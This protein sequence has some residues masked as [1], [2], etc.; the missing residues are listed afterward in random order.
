MGRAPILAWLLLCFILGGMI[1]LLGSIASFT[2]AWILPGL[3]EVTALEDTRTGY[4]PNNSSLAGLWYPPKDT[5]INNL[6]DV[7]DGEGVYGFIFNDSAAPAGNDYYGGYDYCNMP[8]VKKE[9]YQEVTEG[10]TLEYV[11]VVSISCHQLL[12]SKTDP[13]NRSTVTTNA[14]PTPITPLPT[15]PIPGTAATK[16][17]SSTANPSTQQTTTQ[18]PHTGQ[19]TPAARTLLRQPD[20][21]GHVN[22]PKSLG[23]D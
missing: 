16:A 7:I 18:L 17:S 5:Q 11:E 15:K 23:E 9:N 8:H 21:T 22:S 1:W 4:K 20:S 3:L 6:N 10:Y 2:A 12:S 14:H 19:S 13:P